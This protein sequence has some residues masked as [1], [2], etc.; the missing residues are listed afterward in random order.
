MQLVAV[1]INQVNSNCLWC[2]ILLAW[3]QDFKRS[4]MPNKHNENDQSTPGTPYYVAPQVLKGDYNE[5]C[6]IW[7]IGVIMFILLSGYP[8]FYG[9][10]DSEIL[11]KVRKGKFS[12]PTEAEDGVEFSGGAKDLIT[13]M[14]TYAEDDRVFVIQQLFVM[15]SSDCD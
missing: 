13:K 9:E 4:N 2:T 6:D 11:Q 3:Q 12:F 10:K 1:Q 15:R 5:K 14:L 7:S 8:P